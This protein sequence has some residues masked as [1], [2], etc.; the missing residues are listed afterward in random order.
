MEPNAW[1]TPGAISG[2]LGLQRNS[3]GGKLKKMSAKMQRQ[4]YGLEKAGFW[5]NFVVYKGS[6]EAGVYGK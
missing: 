4:S 1:V 2:V 6:W 5:D 3:S